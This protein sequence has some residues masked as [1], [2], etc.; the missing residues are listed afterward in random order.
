MG[1]LIKLLFMTICHQFQEY[2]FQLFQKNSYLHKFEKNKLRLYKLLVTSYESLKN[3]YFENC[4]E[5]DK[6]RL[7]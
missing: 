3:F 4:T 5:I 2:H 7:N 6:K 1:V